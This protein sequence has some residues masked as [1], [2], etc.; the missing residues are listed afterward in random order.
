MAKTHQGATEAFEGH[1]GATGLQTQGL[2]ITDGERRATPLTK[3]VLRLCSCAGAGVV[4]KRATRGSLGSGDISDAALSRLAKLVTGRVEAGRGGWDL[5]ASTCPRWLPVFCHFPSVLWSPGEEGPACFT[6]GPLEAEQSGKE[7][8]AAAS[9]PRQGQPVAHVAVRGSLCARLCR[10][11]TFFLSPHH[12]KRENGPGDPRVCMRR[13]Q[14]QALTQV[15]LC[16]MQ[17]W[18]IQQRDRH[19][20]ILSPSL[21]DVG[22]NLGFASL[23]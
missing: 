13:A 9:G 17:M 14:C 2:Q 12:S 18:H 15:S 21:Q 3:L 1:R 22:S 23:L 20:C 8:L 6:L 16:L 4:S 11:Q 7:V 5:R 19:K 10:V